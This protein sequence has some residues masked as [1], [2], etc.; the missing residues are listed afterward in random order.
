MVCVHLGM[1]SGY[2]G[3]DSGYLEMDSVYLEMTPAIWRSTLTSMVN[4]RW[5]TRCSDITYRCTEAISRCTETTSKFQ[6][7]SPSI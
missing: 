6:R 2:L 3:M 4:W 7:P 5:N 1:D